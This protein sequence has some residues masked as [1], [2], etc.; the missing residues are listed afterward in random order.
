MPVDAGLR[1]AGASNL[2]VVKGC[3]VE[4]PLAGGIE[5]AVKAAESA[6]ATW[7]PKFRGILEPRKTEFAAFP[8]KATLFK[9]AFWETSGNSR[10][11]GA[12]LRVLFWCFQG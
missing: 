4:A 7:P 8:F 3:E 10:W 1:A 5:E 11:L 2:C 6:E 12:C 9:R